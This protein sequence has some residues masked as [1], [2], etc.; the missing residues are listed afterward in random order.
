MF[1]GGKTA[2]EVIAEKGFEQISDSSAIEK[3]VDEIIENNHN[4]VTA[5][6]NGNEKLFG[7]FVGQTMKASGG[8]ANPKIVNELLK[9]KLKNQ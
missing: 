9:T 6:R 1:A 7:F 5:Y 4:Q 2:A 8:R 3:I